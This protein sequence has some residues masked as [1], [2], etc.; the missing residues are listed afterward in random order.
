MKRIA[1]LAFSSLCVTGMVSADEIQD[2]SAASRPVVQEFAG[3]LQGSLGKAMQ[4]GGPTNAID[5]CNKAAPHI[6]QEQSAKHG[7]EIGRTS[8]KTRN[9]ANA[10]DAWEQQVLQAFEE[11]KAKGEDV[12]KMEYAE[13]VAE[14]GKQYFR[15]MKAIPTGELC[16]KCHGAEIEPGVKAK[17]DE[18]YPND[19]ARGFK[20]GDIRGAFTI[21]QPM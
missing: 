10:P 2:R 15:Y 1:V 5:A 9:D 3:A 12:A 18:L 8:L 16:L 13:V 17:L 21:K 11:R 7:W 19:K 20:L 4:E 6:A 14:G